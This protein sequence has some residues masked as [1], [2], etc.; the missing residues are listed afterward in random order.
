MRIS[1]W[2]SDVCSS[3]LQLQ[4]DLLV[5]ISKRKDVETGARGYAL[6]GDES[7][8]ATFE[9]GKKD[10]VRYL[11]GL[12]ELTEDDPVQ[13]L[14]RREIDRLT[15]RRIDLADNL[16]ALTAAAEPVPDPQTASTLKQGKS[17]MD[18]AR[19]TVELAASHEIGRAH[20]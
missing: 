18:Q 7:Y 16:V 5:L 13:R 11:D 3:D 15:R 19:R 14:N 8:L 2:S 12:P 6:T 4:R 9:A 10:V 17:V 20:V 1:D